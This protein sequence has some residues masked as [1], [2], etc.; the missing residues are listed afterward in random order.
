MK[1]N[2]GEIILPKKSPDLFCSKN[3]KPKVCTDSRVAF[4]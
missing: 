1:K 2:E 3:E 4:E